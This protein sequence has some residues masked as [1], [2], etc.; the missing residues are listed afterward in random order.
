MEVLGLNDHVD[1]STYIALCNGV[2]LDVNLCGLP[3]YKD[4]DWN[5]LCLPFDLTIEGSCLDGDNVLAM[6]LDKETSGLSGTT[7]TLNFTKATTIPAGTPFIIKWDNMHVIYCISTIYGVTIDNTDGSVTSS[8]GY[9]TFKGTYDRL[10]W[11]TE[12]NSILFLGANNTL[13]WP[14]PSN[15]QTPYLNAF[16]AYFQL[17]NGLTAADVSSARMNFDG[18]NE[19]N[20]VKEV[21]TPEGVSVARNKGVKDDSW[22]TVNGVK[23]SGKP[24]KAGLYIHNGK[25]VIIK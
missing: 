14:Q 18:E 3:V 13:Y 6:T 15:N 8:D 19:V 21:L 5:T 2:T 9:V 24:T 7:L 4:G 11:N 1:N 10:E 20:G 16:R 12:N 17:N 25:K 23:L 22:Y